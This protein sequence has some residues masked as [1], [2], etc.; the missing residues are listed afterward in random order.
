MEKINIFGGNGHAKV[1][2]E[3]IR[4]HDTYGSITVQDLNP[5]VKSCLNL[6][7]V[8]RVEELDTSVPC[9][10]GVGNNETRKKMVDNYKDHFH[11]AP[12]IIHSAATVSKSASIGEGTVVFAQTAINAEAKIGKHCIINTG[13]VVEHECILED[14]VHISPTAALGGDVHVGEGTHIGMGAKVIQGIRIG[15]WCTI[16]AGAVVIEDIPDNCTAVGVPAKPI[17]YH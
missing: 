3:A 1:V 15:K 7:V 6:T 12:P 17:K 16:G 4:S 2:I 5:Q 11:F 10:I 8:Q 13:A 14:F 9:I